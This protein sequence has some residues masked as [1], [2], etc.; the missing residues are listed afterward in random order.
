MQDFIQ[1][2]DGK[3]WGYAY[4]RPRS[5]KVVAQA[6]AAGG[7]TGYLPLMPKARLHHGSKVISHVPMIPGYIFLA[8][9]DLG[10]SDIRCREKHIVHVEL[11]RNPDSEAVLISELNV[12]RHFEVIAQ[13]ERVLV[14]PGLQTGDKVLITAGELK[15]METF[16]VRRDDDHNA[17]IVNLTMLEHSVEYPVSAEMLKKITE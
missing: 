9:D 16:V 15:G 12:L 1:K 3:Y 2:I 7:I 14:N 4:C 10:R 17:I 5:E 11:L 8:A 13:T 6:L